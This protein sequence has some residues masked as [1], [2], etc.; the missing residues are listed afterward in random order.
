M[1]NL[2]GNTMI[3]SKN[4]FRF[5][6]VVCLDCT[7]IQHHC[8]ECNIKQEEQSLCQSEYAV[9]ALEILTPLCQDHTISFY[10]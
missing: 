3:F 10:M 8:K 7:R 6:F 4:D 5:L 2:S 9:W 1:L